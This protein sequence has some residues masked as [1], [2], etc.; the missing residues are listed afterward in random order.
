MLITGASGKVGK[1]LVKQLIEKGYAV[2]IL[3]HKTKL[4]G[5]AINDVEMVK[6]DLID[7]SSL[8]SAVESVETVCHMAA[9]FDIFPPYKYEA[10]NDVIGLNT[11]LKVLLLRVNTQ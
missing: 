1:R 10:D 9:G 4:E 11:R 3:I 6:G 2:R 5:F 8:E 7:P